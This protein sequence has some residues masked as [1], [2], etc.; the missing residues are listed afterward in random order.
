LVRVD[1]SGVPGEIPWNPQAGQL[2]AARLEGID[3]FVNLSGVNLANR[4]S[5]EMKTRFR[6]SRIPLTKLI[7]A[8]L[9]RLSRRPRVFY[10]SS[11]IGIY[12]AERGDELLDEG[13]SHGSDFLARLCEEWEAATALAAS[14]GI[15]VVNARQGIVLNPAG[16][17]LEKLLI[18][19]RMGAGGR[20]GSGDQWV[21]WIA[22][23]DIVTAIEFALSNESLSGAVNFTA[24]NPVTNEELAKTLGKVLHRPAVAPVPAPIIRLMLGRE[25]A[26]STVL[27][28][29]RVIPRAL[30]DAR[31]PFAYP[32][33]ES[34]LAHELRA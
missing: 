6:E 24:P 22:L 3:A 17:A 26:D 29:Q 33:L 28:S 8:T 15:R 4:W 7:A 13:S 9:A 1:A 18:P 12:G 11:A 30:T 31:F 34:A 32:E 23:S 25:M 5:A 16:G 27:A 21:S 14:A 10:S 2:D 19:F 20:V